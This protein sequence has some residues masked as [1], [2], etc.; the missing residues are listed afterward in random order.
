MG[1]ITLSVDDDFEQEF[2]M[3][4]KKSGLSPVQFLKGIINRNNYDDEWIPNEETKK[5]M[6]EV[7]KGK[8]QS[9]EVNS[10]KELL[11]AMEKINNE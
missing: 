8:Y 2:Y 10:V 6:E 7:E 11:A 5:A 3:R 4:V 1:T 9:I